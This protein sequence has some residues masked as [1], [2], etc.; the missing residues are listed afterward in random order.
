MESNIYQMMICE[1]C[2]YPPNFITV[3]KP[4]SDGEIRLCVTCRECGDYW[5]EPES[6]TPSV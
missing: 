1:D 5:E 6:S 3:T 4:G 2:P